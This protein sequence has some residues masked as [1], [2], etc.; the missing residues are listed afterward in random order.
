MILNTLQVNRRRTDCRPL[1]IASRSGKLKGQN[2]RGTG[3][4]QKNQPLHKNSST[5]RYDY[6]MDR[7]EL[8]TTL[9]CLA[10]W[11][12]LWF[13]LIANG[14]AFSLWEGFQSVNA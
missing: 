12:V 6:G 2:D 5:L 9:L 13:V 8:K 4:L 3:A 7:G 1:T 11:L 14:V 10:T